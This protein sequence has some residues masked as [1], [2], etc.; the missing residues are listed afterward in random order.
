LYTLH[1]VYGCQWKP[2]ANATI[3]Q[4]VI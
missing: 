1:A 2:K 3:L 4:S